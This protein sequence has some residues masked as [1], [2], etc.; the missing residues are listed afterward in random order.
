MTEDLG[1]TALVVIETLL[2]VVVHA[3]DVDDYIARVQYGW[4]SSA[5]DV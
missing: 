5:F 3:S 1:E 4:I 2:C